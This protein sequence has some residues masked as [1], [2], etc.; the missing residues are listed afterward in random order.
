MY[1]FVRRCRNSLN[2]S[3]LLLCGKLVCNVEIV[4][5]FKSSVAPNLEFLK[6]MVAGSVASDV[7]HSKF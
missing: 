7:S 3:Y 2:V 6:S 1:D 5:F 4:L